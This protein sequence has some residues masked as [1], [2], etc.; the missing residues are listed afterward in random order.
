MVTRRWGGPRPAPYN[1]DAVDSDNDGLVQE[2]TVWERPG[3]TRF[4]SQAGRA[5]AAAITNVP[6]GAVLVDEDGNRV[7]Y[8]PG[9]GTPGRSAPAA[10]Q[11]PP[12]RQL[13]TLEDGG[14]P[15][16]GSVVG[17][18]TKPPEPT[19]DPSTVPVDTTPDQRDL[20]APTSVEELRESIV[21]TAEARI[22]L[23]LYER[24]GLDDEGNPMMVLGRM[25][26]PPLARDEGV[27][28]DVMQK[29]TDWA[30][31]NGF[32]VILT[33]SGDFGGSP[34]RLREFYSRFGFTLNK[35]KSRDFSHTEDMYRRPNAP[36]VSPEQAL[37]EAAE[38][39]EESREELDRAAESAR[40]TLRQVAGEQTRQRAEAMK[41]F[42][43]EQLRH[44]DM[45]EVIQERVD[46]PGRGG[47]LVANLQNVKRLEAEQHRLMSDLM[48]EQMDI[49][50]RLQEASDGE[51]FDDLV[52]QDELIEQRIDLA[53]DRWIALKRADVQIQGILDREGAGDDDAIDATFDA[54]P[55]SDLSQFTM[56]PDGEVAINTDIQTV[57][58]AI[59][60]LQEED[61]DLAEVPDHLLFEGIFGEELTWGGDGELFGI[62]ILEGDG[63]ALDKVEDGQEF[64]NGR[65]TF[66]MIKDDRVDLGHG[67]WN[68]M[69]VFDERTGRLYFLKSS[70]FGNDDAMLEAVGAEFQAQIGFPVDEAGGNARVSPWYGGTH[71]WSLI[72]HVANY[73]PFSDNPT[74]FE[75]AGDADGRRKIRPNSGDA[76]RLLVMD[77]VLNN[78]DR[79]TG[80][81]LVVQDGREDRL[82]PIDHGL[83]GFGRPQ[84]DGPLGYDK[85][86]HAGLLDEIADEA[87][88]Y[89]PKDY[90][91]DVLNNPLDGLWSN[92]RTAPMD[93]WNRQEVE[94]EVLNVLQLLEGLD[95]DE[96]FDPDR[97]GRR[98]VTWTETELQHIAAIKTMARA[99]L[100]YLRAEPESLTRP[101]QG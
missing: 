9:Q 90:Y 20:P 88:Q 36:E 54:T 51:E 98:G 10:P 71:R 83:I 1:P 69:E 53:R 2:G 8:T 6:G 7:D 77:Y 39:L 76:A 91:L 92:S 26:V 23:D 67:V 21:N 74:E 65:F 99:R 35:G 96:L 29:I 61:G 85:I 72:P 89:R 73:S 3:G 22:Q 93:E 5:I 31:E 4:V 18:I 37:E 46:D 33:P 94:A 56:I 24:S 34:K 60:F 52:F 38:Q 66:R 45:L 80:N 97:I 63:S 28:T 49:K 59:T 42:A 95:F 40:D 43:E 75:S 30:D 101:I 87:S 27:G 14:Y 79:H 55:V 64:S 48:A 70:V 41:K 12:A 82:V 50:R 47:E 86:A 68:V 15:T 84:G 17:T 13:P 58:D 81:V 62:D 44:R 78:S 11:T 16:I 57:E 100:D 25:V 32:T 19:V